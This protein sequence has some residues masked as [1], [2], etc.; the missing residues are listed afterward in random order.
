MEDSR[1]RRSVEEE[2]TSSALSPLQAFL[3]VGGLALLAGVFLATRATG[4]PAQAAGDQVMPTSSASQSTPSAPAAESQSSPEPLSEKEAIAEF[5]RLRR[6]LD[7]AYA[8]GNP[9]RIGEF[10]APESPAFTQATKQIRFLR[11]HS[12][13][14]RT[15]TTTRGVKIRTIS[16]NQF[17]LVEKVVIHPRYIDEATGLEA[18][19]DVATQRTTLVWTVVRHNLGW[20][21]YRGEKR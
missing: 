18:D 7:R 19:L 13:L 6:L 4:P 11:R 5:S 21:I 20:R 17:E 12:L 3:L 10:A 15:R 2:P 14:D 16:P 9:A 1:A 8:T